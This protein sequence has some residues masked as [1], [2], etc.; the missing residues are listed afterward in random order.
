MP[1][2]PVAELHDDAATPSTDRR[3][4]RRA[5]VLFAAAAWNAYVWL[6][7]LGIVLDDRQTV[8]F[9]VVHGVLI[10]ISLAFAVAL[11]VIGW[12]MFRESRPGDGA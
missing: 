4:R 3:Q 2:E 12:R 9:R 5:W 8:P 1:S 6:T 7:R 10:V 11:A